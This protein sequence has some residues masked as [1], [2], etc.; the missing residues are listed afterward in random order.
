MSHIRTLILDDD[1]IAHDLL[2][3]RLKQRFTT[4]DIE[5]RLDPKTSGDFDVYFVDND[6]DGHLLAPDLVQEV[7]SRHP[8]AHIVVFSSVLDAATLKSLL[9]HGCDV[10]CDK[11]KPTDIEH[12]LQSVEEYLGKR[13]ESRRLERMQ[14]R[15]L[16]GTVHSIVE[17]LRQWNRRLEL[18]RGNQVIV[19]ESRHESAAPASKP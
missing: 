5:C 19:D 1:P 13:L 2:A 15:G 8:Q 3:Y 4:M 10:A 9:N 6:F 14:S 18:S 12:A 7:R 11:S 17:L 16:L